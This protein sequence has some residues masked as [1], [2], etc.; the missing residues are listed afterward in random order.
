MSKEILCNALCRTMS[1][2]SSVEIKADQTIQWAR[3]SLQQRR[4]D[5][6]KE[7]KNLIAYYKHGNDD[8]STSSSVHAILEQGRVLL[9]DAEAH[10]DILGQYT[11]SSESDGNQQVV[12][13]SQS[14]SISQMDSKTNVPLRLTNDGRFITRFLQETSH[15]DGGQ[16]GSNN[17]NSLSSYSNSSIP[18]FPMEVPCWNNECGDND[19][20]SSHTSDKPTVLQELLQEGEARARLDDLI[21]TVRRQGDDS[22]LKQEELVETPKKRIS[23]FDPS[24]LKSARR[25]ALKKITW[26]AEVAAAD[27]KTRLCTSFKALPLPGGVEVKN[28]LF[29]STQSFQGKLIG[30]VEKLVRRDTKY[31]QLHDRSSSISGTFGEYDS[32]SI[33][34]SRTTQNDSFIVCGYENEADR[35]QA[36]HLHAEKKRKKQQLLDTV[37]Q[38]IIGDIQAPTK[39]DGSVFYGEGGVMLEDP[40]KLRQ[41]IARLEAKLKQKKIQRLATL[42]DIVDIDLNALFDRLYSRESD[43]AKYII[44]RLKNQVCGSVNDFHIIPDADTS[45][46]ETSEPRR[47]SLFRRHEE[48]S[49]EREQKLFKA[50]L[51]LEADTMYGMTGTPEL[52][53]A[54]RS[55]QK[56]KESHD[57][58]LKRAIE[59]EQ[60]KQQ[61]RGA[62][63]KA[64]TETKLKEMEK[65]QKQASSKLKLIKSQVN[66]E[67]Q[68][69]RLETLS[70]PRRIRELIDVEC[71][72]G[73]E[74]TPTLFSKLE[75]PLLSTPTRKTT[76]TNYERS[77]PEEKTSSNLKVPSNN[78]K[79]TEFCGKPSFS[80]ISDKDFAILVKRISKVTPNKVSTIDAQVQIIGN[81]ETL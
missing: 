9:A 13:A 68:T 59:E 39:D 29:A 11:I 22:P 70:R 25:A 21:A 41:D 80:E 26:D 53:R 64:E 63:E 28:D 36:K 10:S 7:K 54:S 73:F 72:T 55:W 19:C 52:S 51:Q 56:A 49:K 45:F 60:R 77:K 71:S 58:T 69:K 27:K 18:E 33:A 75:A 3:E 31:E 4:S 8:E 44:D 6:L 48:W 67:E 30:S 17:C 66:K 12:E 50:R 43:E 78:T 5:L 62:K 32:V 40:S 1:H 38:I 24:S 14:T 76:T 20:P 16:F 23:S 46:T 57:E 65:L 74:E 35:E 61:E 15:A 34:I 37:N 2:D 79:P 42:N 47:K 81:L